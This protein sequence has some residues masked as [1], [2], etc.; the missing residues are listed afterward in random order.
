MRSI[1]SPLDGI[2]SPFGVR[3]GASA[4][5]PPALSLDFTQANL[6]P[7]ITFS[8]T[9]LA[10]M[11]DETGKLTYCPNNL[12]LNS[13]ALSTQ[14]V[15]VAPIA[16][17]LSFKGT[18]SVTKSGTA[19]GALAGTGANDRV[20]EKFTPTAGS[21]TLTVSG[22]VTEAHLEAV[23]YQ[24]TPRPYV[25]TTSAAYYGHR[26]DF[27]PVTLECKGLLIEE[28]RTNLQTYSQDFDNAA[29]TKTGVTIAANAAVAPDGT[30]T[31][32]EL[33][34]ANTSSRAVS[35]GVTVTS[36]TTYTHS[37]FAKKNTNDW[38]ALQANA[39][40]T[41]YSMCFDLTNGVKGS[42]LTGTSAAPSSGIEYVGDGWYR[43][44][45][46]FSSTTDLSGFVLYRVLSADN[47]LSTSGGIYIW[48]AQLEAGSFATSYIPTSSAS[49]TCAADFASMTGTN[50]S[51]WY[52][53]SE[54]TFVITARR[55]H[56]TNGSRLIFANNGTL[57]Q[58]L[59]INLPSNARSSGRVSVDGVLQ[60]NT[61]SANGTAPANQNNT[62]AY[63]YKT[64]D[65]ALCV[66]GGAVV[67]TDSGT[68]PS[69]NRVHIG[70]NGFNGMFLNG[71]IKSLTYYNTRKSNDDLQLLTAA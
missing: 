44:W 4:P 60:G 40:D 17:I 18:G 45:V 52:N 29:W 9:S 55:A 48:G 42:A 63:A 67:T 16:Y 23:T 15:T 21:L 7:R 22:S 30:T 32:D 57:A 13:A 27:E 61:L 46:T 69:V 68:L 66:N 37:I 62:T 33:V 31:A 1:L 6:D 54:G 64:N 12:L 59:D 11:F 35:K 8:R 71:H 43:C 50:F 36:G 20:Y 53:Q 47:T 5:A 41:E 19:T 2:A 49:V 58:V 51:D 25:A 14:S 28:S 24:T 38:I 10:T 39:F 34:S 70:N 65:F 26:R 56:D 3:R